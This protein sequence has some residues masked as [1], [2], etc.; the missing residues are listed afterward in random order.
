MEPP[1]GGTS[2]LWQLIEVPD[3]TGEQAERLVR[4]IGLE[5]FCKVE[6]LL[7]LLDGHPYL[8]EI[9]ARL[10]ADLG[11]AVSAGIDVPYMY[12]QWA[13]GAK[14]DVMKPYRPGAWMRY[15]GG[16]LRTTFDMITRPNRPAQPGPVR[17]SADPAYP[18]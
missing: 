11:L 6:F 14:I 5:G 17:A 2:V 9:N 4:A 13:S 1:L 3:D 12:Y 8:M 7:R 16:D 18:V 15:L 10:T